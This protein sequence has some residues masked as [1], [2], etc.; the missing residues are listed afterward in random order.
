MT[1]FK[2]KTRLFTRTVGDLFFVNFFKEA[3]LIVCFVQMVL[4]M[5]KTIIHTTQY[6]EIE[7]TGLL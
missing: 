6:Q 3:G 7:V 2:E 4:Q 5:D 1:D